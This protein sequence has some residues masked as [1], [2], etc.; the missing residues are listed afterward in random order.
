[1]GENVKYIY[2]SKQDT[3][4]P[5]HVFRNARNFYGAEDNASS[6]V[7]VGY[8]P[9]IVRAYETA[10]VETEVLGV[11]ER[12]ERVRPAA[13]SERELPVIP[14][15]WRDLEWPEYRRLAAEIAGHPVIN[16]ESATKIIEDAAG[17]RS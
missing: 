8:Y 3:R 12:E 16:K 7:V 6:V 14:A 10:G 13:P 5:N 15:N 1:M 2:A 9:E 11:R 17:E 4:F